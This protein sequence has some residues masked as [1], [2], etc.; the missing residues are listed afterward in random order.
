VADAKSK[1]CV[2][3]PSLAGPIPQGSYL[4]SAAAGNPGGEQLA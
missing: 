3:H 1:G 4:E 2:F